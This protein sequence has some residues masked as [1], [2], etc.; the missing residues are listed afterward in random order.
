MNILSIVLQAAATILI[1]D[2]F[3]GLF[4]WLEDAYGREDYPIT[5]RLFTKPNILHHHDPRYFVRHSW[6][7]S[8]WDLTLFCALK[9]RRGSELDLQDI[10]IALISEGSIRL[11]REKLSSWLSPKKLGEVDKISGRLSKS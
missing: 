10:E 5:G 7:Q 4:H 9:A 6:L 3:S 11:D 2:F 1:A 8:S